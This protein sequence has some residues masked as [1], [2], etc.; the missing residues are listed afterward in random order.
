MGGT[1]TISN[2]QPA[3]GNLRIQT[4][5]YGAAIPLVYGKARISG[6]LLWFGGFKPIPHTDTQTQGGKGGGSVRTETTTFTYT[7][8]VIMALAEGPL[9]TVVSAWKGKTR[10]AGAPASVVPITV[11]ENVNVPA[12]GA[13]VAVAHAAAF[14]NDVQVTDNQPESWDWSFG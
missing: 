3:A 6:N 5:V 14:Q 12:G 13:A 7:A 1:T 8:A 10:Y 2:M 11:T 9:N 4:S